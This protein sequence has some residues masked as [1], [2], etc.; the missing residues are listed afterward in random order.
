MEAMRPL[1]GCERLRPAKCRQTEFYRRNQD[2]VGAPVDP[3]QF[4]LV[5]AV[6]PVWS[7][8]PITPIDLSEE[9]SMNASSMGSVAAE[10]SHK[11][12][13]IADCGFQGPMPL[14]DTLGCHGHEMYPQ[15]FIQL[16]GCHDLTSKREVVRR[17]HELQ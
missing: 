12:D 4:I 15:K 6:L 11:R 7:V 14:Q 9:A 3:D 1:P 17:L 2:G 8:G 5:S 10:L 13:V 16:V